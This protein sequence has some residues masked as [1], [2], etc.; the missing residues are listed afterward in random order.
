MDD[1]HSVQTIVGNNLRKYRLQLKL[2]QDELAEKTGI[3]TPFLANLE[4]GSK[5]MS[6]YSLRELCEKLG[7]SADQLLFDHEPNNNIKNIEMLLKDQPEHVI[8]AAEKL[9]RVLVEAV[10]HEEDKNTGPV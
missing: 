3:S 6:I 10:E 2:T 4:R 5:G 1:K 9:V 8:L 7:I